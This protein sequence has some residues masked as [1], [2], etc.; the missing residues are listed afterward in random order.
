MAKNRADAGRGRPAGVVKRTKRQTSRRGFYALLGGIA[1]VGAALIGYLVT[2]PKA[3]PVTAIDTTAGPA[4]AEGYLMGNASAPVQV[5]EFGDFACPSCAQF[6]IL[7]APDI[8]QRL[9][10]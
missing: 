4:Q 6:A 9:V 8:K 5:L 1:L 10:N 2:R 7:A 3:P